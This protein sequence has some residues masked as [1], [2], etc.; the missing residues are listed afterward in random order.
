MLSITLFS[1]E[2]CHLCEQAEQDLNSLQDEYPHQLFVINIDNHPDLV[3]AYGMD[4]PVIEVGPYTLKAPI[5]KKRIE[6]TLSA[7]S[8]R[9][10]YLE[11]V[12]G[13]DYKKRVKRAREISKGDFFSMWFSKHYLMVFNMFV[14]VYF[15]LPF[16]AP[17]FLKIGAETPARVIYRLYGGLC[18]QLSY[19]SW[20]LFGDQPFYP[21][22]LAGIDGYITFHEATGLDEQGLVDARSF[23]GTEYT[24]YKIALCQRDLAIYGSILI[25]GIIFALTGRK[26]KPLPFLVWFLIGILP[27]A[28]DG[29]SQLMGQIFS[30]PALE[31]LQPYFG[32]VAFRESTP[33]L[34]TLTGFLFGFSTAWFG[35]PLVEETMRDARRLLAAKFARLGSNN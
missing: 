8:D 26:I 35:Y 19:R 5:D 25:F 3:S 28:F 13:K 11:E 23:L 7:A 1:R 15:G 31:F 14:L 9:K 6:V 32:F 33:F 21:R 12:G 24:G 17:I 18:H 2:N 16:L 30:Q 20:F 27:I 34:R 22:E 29:L 4:I 10:R